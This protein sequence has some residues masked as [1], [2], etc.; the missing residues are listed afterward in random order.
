ME[1]KQKIVNQLKTLASEI[2]NEHSNKMNWDMVPFNEEEAYE[3]M[4]NNV[5]NQFAQLQNEQEATVV[6]LATI[7]KLLVENLYY[8]LIIQGM[9]KNV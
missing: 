1:D 2:N 5:Y 4:A 7:V 8:Q 6:A 3:T 9:Q